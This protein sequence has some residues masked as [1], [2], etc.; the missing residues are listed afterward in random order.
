MWLLLVFS[1]AVNARPGGG[2]SHSFTTVSFTSEAHCI[3]AK[4]RLTVGAA[5]PAAIPGHSDVIL[6]VNGV[7]VQTQ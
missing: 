4:N 5:V 7:C 2:A 1:A 6:P 3:A